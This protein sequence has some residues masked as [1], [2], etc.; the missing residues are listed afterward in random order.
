MRIGRITGLDPVEVTLESTVLRSD[1]VGFL[2]GYVPAVG[3]VV[4]VSGQS[5][6][7]SARS[8]S[9]LVHGRIDPSAALR[10]ALAIVVFN[11]AAPVENTSSATF[12]A[13]TGA[14][15]SFTKVRGD[16]ALYFTLLVSGFTPS[17]VSAVEYEVAFG[18]I[19]G[20]ATRFLYNAANEHHSSGGSNTVAG[21]AAGPA[22]F[23][24]NWRL[25]LGAGPVHSDANDR[26]SLLIHESLG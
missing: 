23:Q 22:T 4:A 8:A 14:A 5:A 16:S 26:I 20:F 15:G 11:I 12:V 19:A 3:D 7:P 25:A 6:Q 24:V 10:P 13:I 21:V 1:A 9:W 2:N 18:G 17:A